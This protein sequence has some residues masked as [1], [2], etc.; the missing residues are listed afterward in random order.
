MCNCIIVLL[1]YCTITSTSLP[2]HVRVKLGDCTIKTK[3]TVVLAS[4]VLL[5]TSFIQSDIFSACILIGMSS[6]INSSGHTA[7]VGSYANAS[8]INQ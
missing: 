6:C 4:Q 5:K 2:D 1:L 8:A 3:L 7:D